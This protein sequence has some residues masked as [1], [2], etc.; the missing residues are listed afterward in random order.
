MAK[1]TVG[2]PT[3]NAERHIAEAIESM[4]AQSYRDFELLISDNAST[5]RTEDI[6]RHYQRSDSRITYV[7]QLQNL[8]ATE[9]YNFVFRESNSE[10]FKWASSND[11]CT[12][13]TLEN[14]INEI[15]KDPLV[16]LCYPPAKLFEKSLEDARDYEDNMVTVADSSVTRFFHVVDNMALNNVM[17]GVTKSDALRRTPLIKE[18][19]Y[20]DRNMVAELALIGKIVSA[21]D[22]YFYRRMDA[23]SA[24]KLKSGADLLAHFDPRLKRPISFANWRVFSG[25]LSSLIRCKI[26]AASLLGTV[27]KLG[28]RL[29]W[30]K[31]ALWGDIAAAFRY[32][33]D[34]ARK[35]LSRRDHLKG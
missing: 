23:E 19:P 31:G 3:Y 2:M 33:V 8:G 26:G 34:D 35:T 11:Y 20:A 15:D 25:Y 1:L 10:L 24:T 21:S 32:A 7:R 18:F 13:K 12:E 6:C 29:W 4:L 30:S 28:R 5:D 22:C 16:V 27:P 14:C 9:N 17:N